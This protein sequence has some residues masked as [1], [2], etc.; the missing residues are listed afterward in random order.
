MEDFEYDKSLEHF[1]GV[2]CKALVE[3]VRST[4]R[5]VESYVE[6]YGKESPGFLCYP[7]FKEVYMT[8]AHPH[9]A[10]AP[11]EGK[12][13]ALFNLFDV[14]SRGKIAKADFVATL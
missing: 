4:R 14:Q 2:A 8:H 10:P 12:L 11:E 7:E 9:E 3:E 1:F 5:S 6:Q 13:L